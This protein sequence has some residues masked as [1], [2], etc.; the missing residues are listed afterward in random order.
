MKKRNSV[1]PAVFLIIRKKNKI[2][3]LKR[4]NTNH[5]D[6][7]YS[8]IAGHVDKNESATTAICREAYEEAGILVDPNDL[9]FSYLLYKKQEEERIDIFF[10]VSKWNGDIKNVEPNKCSDLSFFDINNLPLN[11]IDYVVKVIIDIKNNLSF[12]EFGF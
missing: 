3:L 9:E 4:K 1:I 6:G 7:K 10:T 11:T 5:E 12:G 8:L 2:L